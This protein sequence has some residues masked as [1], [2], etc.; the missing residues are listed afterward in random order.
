MTH[1]QEE[2]S[3]L[4]KCQESGCWYLTWRTVL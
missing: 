3:N 2:I 4:Q 1:R